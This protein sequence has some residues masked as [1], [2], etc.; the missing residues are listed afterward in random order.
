M[1]YKS[2]N[3]VS[4][5]H[6][7]F[8]TILKDFYCPP[9]L[10]CIFLAIE[11]LQIC[12]AHLILEENAHHLEIVHINNTIFSKIVVPVIISTYTQKHLGSS[13]SAS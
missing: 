3:Q 2:V 4:G 7:C 10:Y 9:I 13:H 12:T 6:L 5:L 11:A 8:I 1:P